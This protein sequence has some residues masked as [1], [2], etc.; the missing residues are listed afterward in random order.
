MNWTNNTHQKSKRIALLLR[1]IRSWFF[2]G[3]VLLLLINSAVAQRPLP[4]LWGIRVHDDA[5]VL[6]QETVDYLENYLEVYEDS[7]SNQ[8]AIL[9]I[10]SL[11]GEAIEDYSI[12]LAEKWKLGQEGKDNGVLLLIAVDDR[13][14]R[15]EV[16]YGL[17]GVLTDL[18]CQRIIRN[19]MAPNFR[20]DDYNAG[21]SAAV[22]AIIAAIGGEYSAE[23]K[24]ATTIE[25][26]DWKV[27]LL[28]GLFVFSILG[29][30]TFVGL[31][32]PGCTGWFLYAFLIPFYATFPMFIL[33]INGGIT[34][35]ATYAIAFPILKLV[36]GKTDWG[37][38][39]TSKVGEGKGG[40]GWSSGSGW[41]S[42]GGSGGGGFSG[43]GGSFGGGGSSGSW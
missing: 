28:I 22:K 19:E 38:R 13:K 36:L 23:D 27:R 33:G 14:M 25:N 30:F 41:S 17:E 43:G 37:K 24:D 12:R 40:K 18:I 42:G 1:Y 26:L 16:G 29:I 7:T 31:F 20:K 15:I 2:T 5:Q 35:L 32:I 34:A 21:V 8:V 6:T 3:S 39:M 11:D 9:I 10:K 4:E